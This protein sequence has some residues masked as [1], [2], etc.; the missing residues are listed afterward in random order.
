MKFLLDNIKSMLPTVSNF[1]NK[2]LNYLIILRMFYWLEI[3][4]TSHESWVWIIQRLVYSINIQNIIKNL[5]YV[6][7][8]IVLF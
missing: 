3:I 2:N 5:Q 6:L 4:K 7:N 1:S 8:I